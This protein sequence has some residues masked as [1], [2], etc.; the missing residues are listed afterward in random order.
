MH[1]RHKNVLDTHMKLE[2]KQ[3]IITKC[4]YT[5]KCAN[6]IVYL[7]GTLPVFIKEFATTYIP[8]I[9]SLR[10]CAYVA[11][12]PGMHT[13][14]LAMILESTVPYPEEGTV[15]WHVIITHKYACDVQYNNVFA[16][17]ELLI[18]YIWP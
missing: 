10:G 3:A 6:I 9:S 16:S 2:K 18:G 17:Q 5:Q 15:I 14:F 13:P 4:L 11:L 7:P 1:G 12:V 8:D